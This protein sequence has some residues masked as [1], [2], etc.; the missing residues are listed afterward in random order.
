MWA[1][2]K[3]LDE[4]LQEWRENELPAATTKSVIWELIT[5]LNKIIKMSIKD[6]LEEKEIQSEPS[7]Q[8]VK[9]TCRLPFE[10]M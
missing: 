5:H 10:K 1:G 6:G 3:T 4:G 2:N 8:G 9:K 7:I